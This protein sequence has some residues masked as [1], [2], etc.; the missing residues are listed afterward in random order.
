MSY[1]DLYKVSEAEK[2]TG[3]RAIE[4]LQGSNNL[5]IVRFSNVPIKVDF[6]I[7][8]WNSK[9]KSE[10]N[11]CGVSKKAISIAFTKLHLIETE[12][13]L[14]LSTRNAVQMD[15]ET[16]NNAAAGYDLDASIDKIVGNESTIDNDLSLAP[17]KNTDQE[18]LVNLILSTKHELFLDQHVHPIIITQGNVGGSGIN[19]VNEPIVFFCERINDFKIPVLIGPLIE[20][21]LV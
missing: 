21:A 2:K 16:A 10:A 12:K 3:L 18:K 8:D 15:E 1:D 17:V 5:V 11:D 6:G 4:P 14:E 19:G 9:F 13:L 7:K 20:F